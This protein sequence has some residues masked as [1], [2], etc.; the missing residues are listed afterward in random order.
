MLFSQARP[1]H[2]TTYAGS[3]S[4]DF[5]AVCICFKLRYIRLDIG[6]KGWVRTQSRKVGKGAWKFHLYFVV[7]NWRETM[8]L[9]GFNL[10]LLLE[11]Q[12]QFEFVKSLGA[13]YIRCP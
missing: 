2:F 3:G 12:T 11:E 6:S 4:G 8:V 10:S 7:K 1:S 9:D 13:V 5:E